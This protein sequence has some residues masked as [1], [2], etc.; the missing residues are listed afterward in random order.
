MAWTLTLS[1]ILPSDSAI[2]VFGQL[3]FSGN[4]T[5]GGD[6]GTLQTGANT[7]GLYS[8][9]AT[10]S[11]HADRPPVS[12]N[13]Q[14]DGGYIGVLIPGNGPSNFKLKVLNP[15]SGSELAAGAYPAALTGAVQHTLGLV[16]L[17]NL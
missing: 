7:A 9:M 13:V 12:F 15:A 2:A 11:L 3:A 14:L 16:Y 17:R 1:S 8:H 10:S 5:A 4:Y 6:T